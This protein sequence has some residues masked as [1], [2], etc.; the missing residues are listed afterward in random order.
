VKRLYVARGEFAEM[1]SW[2]D[3]EQRRD[4]EKERR[5]SWEDDK[6]H[7]KAYQVE[8]QRG[9]TINKLVAI[10]VEA[11]GFARYDRGKWKRRIVRAI[12]SSAGGS[13][14]DVAGQIR[15]LVTAL[16]S[17][18]ER[19]IPKLRELATVHPSEFAQ[20][21][22]GNFVQVAFDMLADGEVAE[23]R[24]LRD[25]L[26]ARL[27]LVAD[28]L[29]GDNPSPARRLAAQAAAFNW[30]ECWLL[31]MKAANVGVDRQTLEGS[32]RQTAATR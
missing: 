13:T 18:D 27:C 14:S 10:G 4:G 21:V 3:R 2:D 23:D 17:G 6:I 11:L 22:E 9:Q 31:N 32:R 24:K 1:L 20:Q 28:E 5:N 15:K 7:R 30:A 12:P 25:D 16:A 19:A 26:V 8:R 29:G